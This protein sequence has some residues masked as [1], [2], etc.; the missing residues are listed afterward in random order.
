MVSARSTRKPFV[1][2]ST[3]LTHPNLDPRGSNNVNITI[4]QVVKGDVILEQGGK[5]KIEVKK[6]RTYACSSLGT[7]IN[8]RFC[9]ERGTEVK[10]E[11]GAKAVTDEEIDGFL[12]EQPPIE[13]RDYESGVLV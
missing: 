7:H 10:I 11:R 2:C 1:S 5:K 9:Y 8:D 6:V 12:D 3:A 13:M 4:E